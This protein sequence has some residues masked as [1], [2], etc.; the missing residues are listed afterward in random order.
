MK[1]PQEISILRPQPAS[2]FNVETLTGL[3][4]VNDNADIEHHVISS[5]GKKI[6]KGKSGKKI[7]KT[8]SEEQTCCPSTQVFRLFVKNGQYVYARAADIIMIESCDHLVKVYL[9][10]CN[11]AKLAL[12]HNTL[13]DFLLQLPQSQFLRIGRFCAVNIS[14]LSGGSCNDQTFEFDFKISV[15]LTHSVSHKVFSAIGK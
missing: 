14:R 2:S 12:R 1:E 8:E 15:K 9:G 4:Y 5:P 6:T 3:L 7:A 11:E 10:I 13:K